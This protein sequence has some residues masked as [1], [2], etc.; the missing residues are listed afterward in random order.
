ML[1]L[2]FFYI[3]GGVSRLVYSP[4]LIHKI[5][6][7]YEDARFVYCEDGKFDKRFVRNLETSW[8]EIPDQEGENTGEFCPQ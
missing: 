4:A 5:T 3:D 7:L 2:R 6:H 8:T 1:W